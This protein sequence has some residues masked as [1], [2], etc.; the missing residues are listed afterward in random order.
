MPDCDDLRI[1]GTLS[2]SGITGGVSIQDTRIMV[3]D[4]SGIFGH[5]GHSYQPMAVAGRPGVVLTGDGLPL[6]RFITLPL[7]ITRW[8]EVSRGAI[9]AP[10]EGAQLWD[11]TDLLLGYLANRNGFYLEVDDPD[12]TSRFA[13][14][15]AV[16]PAA[17]SQ[18]EWRRMAVGLI[19]PWPYWKLGDTQFSDTASGGGTITITGNVPVFDPVITFSGAGTYTNTTAGWTL[20]TTGACVV[21]VGARTVQ[22]GGVNNDNLLTRT[23]RE[24]AWFEVGANSITRSVS[25]TTVLRQQY[26]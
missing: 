20:T 8:N 1:G 12:G 17:I 25:C 15:Y 23:D 24:W 5:V 19:A 13:F 16:T 10:S 26:E 9:T 6:E 3:S 14:C 22:V 18:I 2:G 11:N 7:L 21:D 4:W